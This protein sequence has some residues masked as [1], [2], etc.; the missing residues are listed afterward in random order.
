MVKTIHQTRLAGLPCKLMIWTGLA[1]ACSSTLHG[2]DAQ[3][4]S[5][6]HLPATITE[7]IDEWFWPDPYSHLGHV[8]NNGPG[9]EFVRIASDPQ[10]GSDARLSADQ[11]RLIS[12]IAKN[13]SENGTSGRVAEREQRWRDAERDARKLLNQTQ[14]QRVDQLVIQRRG[15]RA[16]SDPEMVEELTLTSEQ[17]SMIRAAIKRHATRVAENARE[18]TVREGRLRDQEDVDGEQL[19]TQSMALNRE[20]VQRGWLSHRQVW[21][22]IRMILSIDQAR[23]FEELRGTRPGGNETTSPTV[24][25]RESRCRIV[26]NQLRQRLRSDLKTPE[27][28]HPGSVMMTCYGKKPPTEGSPRD[29]FQSMVPQTYQDYILMHP[30]LHQL[31]FDRQASVDVAESTFEYVDE[32]IPESLDAAI[33]LMLK[34]RVQTARLAAEVIRQRRD[35]LSTEQWIRIVEG[36]QFVPA[37]REQ[38]PIG[39]KVNVW[40]HGAIPFGFLLLDNPK[41]AGITVQMRTLLDGKTMATTPDSG[42]RQNLP[43]VLLGKQPIGNHTIEYQADYRLTVGREVITGQCRSGEIDFQ[44]IADQPDALAATMTDALHAQVS[45]SI[46]ALPISQGRERTYSTPAGQGKFRP[47]A[48]LRIPYLELTDPLPVALAMKVDVYFDDADQPHSRPEW[49]VPAGKVSRY[50]V[51]GMIGDGRLIDALSRRADGDGLV[52]ATIV[53]IP[54]RSTALS[55]ALIESYYPETIKVQAQWQLLSGG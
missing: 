10:A 3:Q 28:Q 38:Y 37:I 49:I 23:L 18:L 2:I 36:Y 47:V 12:A 26:K 53:L 20:R 42:W 48:K 19:K 14:Q 55:H 41:I 46:R 35:R 51:E 15:Y 5:D 4:P 7:L 31:E 52:D 9:W 33:D 29:L 17:S 27:N 44:V 40:G 34:A 50:E 30:K 54:D 25:R 39:V 24:D 8:R 13:A 16:F 6:Q 11:I 22:D 32:S 43:D 1:M 21:S 45:A